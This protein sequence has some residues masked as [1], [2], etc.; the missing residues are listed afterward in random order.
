MFEDELRK[1][2]KHTFSRKIKLSL[3]AI[4]YYL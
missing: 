1:K 3:Y 2:I 4:M